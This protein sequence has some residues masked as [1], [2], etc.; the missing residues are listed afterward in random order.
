[1][2]KRLTNGFETALPPSAWGGLGLF[3]C[4]ETC[5]QARWLGPSFVS[6]APQRGF[7]FSGFPTG[8]R[9]PPNP[10]GRSVQRP[11]E[12]SISAPRRGALAMAP[13]PVRHV[14]G[15]CAAR[16]VS[17][18]HGHHKLLAGKDMADPGMQPFHRAN[19]CRND[20]WGRELQ[21]PSPAP[22]CHQAG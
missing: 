15:S 12:F 10:F 6:K 11:S 7:K 2:K 3:F 21:A 9:Q 5:P 19:M 18:D 16:N 20:T 13:P 22:W 8:Y 1:M 17:F 4:K 14:R